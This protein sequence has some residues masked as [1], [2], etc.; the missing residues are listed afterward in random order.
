MARFSVPLVAG[1]L[2]LGGFALGASRARDTHR[3]WSSQAT[4]MER[5]VEAAPNSPE[6]P[7]Y[8]GSLA[9]AHGDLDQAAGYFETSIELFPRN[10]RVLLNLG[11]IRAQQQQYSLATRI[12]HD[13][14]IL[15]DRIMPRSSVA[16]KAHLSLG[17]LLGGQS[18]DDAA[19]QEFHKA[20][21]ADSTNVTA[22][23]S[24]GMLEALS[25]STAREG[26]RRLNRALERDPEGRE[27]G[28]MA[29]RAR[30]V[31]DRAVL[32]ITEI[33]GNREAYESG[34]Q[35]PDTTSVPAERSRA[36]SE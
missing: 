26:I 13:T 18:L 1:L 31:R 19:L 17:T 15:S 36:G 25:F 33:A 16:A 35:P 32:Y 30:E 27:L 34:M 5:L 12:L 14:A 7:A 29:Q 23:A 11:L 3:A 28:A 8:R 20:L 2:A 22:L 4:L 6:I 9:M 24:A 21:A 10:P